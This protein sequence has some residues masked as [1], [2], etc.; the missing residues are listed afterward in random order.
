LLIG[1]NDI[2]IDTL[3]QAE[4]SEL[5][6]SVWSKTIDNLGPIRISDPNNGTVP[7]VIAEV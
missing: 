1:S 6:I 2:K 4:L 7:F 5:I 3:F